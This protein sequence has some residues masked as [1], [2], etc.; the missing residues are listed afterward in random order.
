MS[1][2]PLGEGNIAFPREPLRHDNVAHGACVVFTQLRLV[3]DDAARFHHDHGIGPE[4]LLERLE[5]TL[6]CT[7]FGCA[8]ECWHAGAPVRGARHFCLAL[9]T[10]DTLPQN[11]C[12]R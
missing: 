6:S 10:G 4:A 9:V 5:E 12:R 8:S 7:L 11:V 2:N 3:G 1:H